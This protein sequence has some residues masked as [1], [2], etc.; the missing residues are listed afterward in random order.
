MNANLPSDTNLAPYRATAEQILR[1]RQDSRIPYSPALIY[2][3]GGALH[4]T[5][6]DTARAQYV[7]VSAVV[8]LVDLP[9]SSTTPTPR[10]GAELSRT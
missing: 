7:P 1:I 6:A 4:I 2:R 10:Q 8:E 5:T 9:F 3:E